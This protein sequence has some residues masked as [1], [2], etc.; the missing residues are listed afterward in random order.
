MGLLLSL[1]LVAVGLFPK[2]GHRMSSPYGEVTDKANHEPPPQ[3]GMD[4]HSGLIF[5]R[6]PTYTTDNNC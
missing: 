1:Q 5:L 2:Q 6:V 4:L 3:L